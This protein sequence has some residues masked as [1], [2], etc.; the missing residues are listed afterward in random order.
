MCFGRRGKKSL[1]LLSK[2]NNN[3]NSNNND[4]AQYRYNISSPTPARVHYPFHNHTPPSTQQHFTEMSG[5]FN[6]TAPS[7]TL[8]QTR[9]KP[10]TPPGGSGGGGEVGGGGTSTTD[11]VPPADPPPPFTPYTS[12]T[13]LPPPPPV[14]SHDTSPTSNAPGDLSDAGYNFCHQNPLIPPQHLTT[15]SLREISMGALTL[16]PPPYNNHHRN[17]SNSL[18]LT[19]APKSSLPIVSTAA[20]C[21][22]TTLL[23][24]QPLYAAGYHHPAN[25]HLPKRIY[26]EIRILR[27]PPRTQEATVAIGFAAKPYPSFRLP[28]WNRGSLGVHGDDGRRYCNDS[29][30]GKD[31][32]QGGWRAGER[33]GIGMCF[34]ADA[35]GG[36]VW[37]TRNGE[38]VGG[39]WL[40]EE[41]DAERD[42]D[43]R[44]GLD[45]RWDVYAALGV[46]GGGIQVEVLKFE[47]V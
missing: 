36:E 34:G 14:I 26:F 9:D 18:T 22:D 40:D 28:G 29:Y 24:S 23:S 32:V 45:G 17:H 4:N 3:S 46:W 16:L 41:V 6:P 15:A 12:E 5:P 33:V 8:S 11:F 1:L 47:S 20:G 43:P 13:D 10:P 27:L 19:S 35:T 38:R 42:W 30:G 7:Y 2:D 31:F 21:L 39:W 25:T 37:F 44:V